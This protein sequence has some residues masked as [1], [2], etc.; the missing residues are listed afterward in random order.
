MEFQE[1]SQ[2]VPLYS[3]TLKLRTMNRIKR[4]RQQWF[5]KYIN[6]VLGRPWVFW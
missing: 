3:P 2:G 6:K 4:S 1:D 5:R